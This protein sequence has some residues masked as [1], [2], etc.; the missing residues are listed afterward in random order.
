MARRRARKLSAP[1]FFFYSVTLILLLV[2]AASL[3]GLVIGA[4]SD[5]T[6][7]ISFTVCFSL[8]LSFIVVSYLLHKGKSLKKIVKELGLSRSALTTKTIGYGILLFAIYIVILFA[9]AAYSVTTGNQVNSNVQQ[10]LGGYPLW[11]IVFVS[12]IAPLNE[13][14]AFRGFLVPRIGFLASGILFGIL[15][16]G[17]GSWSEII[18]ALWFGITGGYVFKRTKSLYPTLITHMAVNVLTAI[19][20]LSVIHPMMSLV[21]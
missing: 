7:S 10:A 16:F 17:Y 8:L 20:I 9:V 5:L 13:E 14:I 2:A 4:L 19:T 12:V 1:K 15:H 6:A 11:A 21:H 18:V 3:I